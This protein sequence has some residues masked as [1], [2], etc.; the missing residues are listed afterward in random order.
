MLNIFKRKKDSI[1]NHVIKTELSIVQRSS[2][3]NEVT[4]KCFINNQYH[5]EYVTPMFVLSVFRMFTDISPIM[6]KNDDGSVSEY[7]DVEATYK[8]SIDNKVMD[9]IVDKCKYAYID[10]LFLEVLDS[11]EYKK[12]LL[13]STASSISDEIILSVTNIINSLKESINN[14]DPSQYKDII[15]LA[16]NAN[17]FNVTKND[18]INGIVKNLP[19]KEENKAETK[20]DKV[21][22]ITPIPSPIEDK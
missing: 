6:L 10:N 9:T 2:I 4:E 12:E 8:Y 16:K 15:E 22:N 20:S 11:I 18:F 1:S 7:V 13:I 3:I 21:D 5:S 14:F 17:K 19:K